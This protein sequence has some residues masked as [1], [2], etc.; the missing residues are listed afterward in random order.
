ME[1]TKK[2]IQNQGLS[3]ILAS[4]PRNPTGQVS[5]IVILHIGCIITAF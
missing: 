2:D 1:Q 3:V 4:N 5:Q